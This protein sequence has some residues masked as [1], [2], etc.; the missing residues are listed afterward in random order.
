MVWR[1]IRVNDTFKPIYAQGAGNVEKGLGEVTNWSS[2]SLVRLQSPPPRPFH[3]IFVLSHSGN[4]DSCYGKHTKE[5]AWWMQL[6]L[7]I[8]GFHQPIAIF[9]ETM[10]T[11]T[12]GEGRKRALQA[13][14]NFNQRG[15]ALTLINKM[16]GKHTFIDERACQL[17]VTKTSS[18]TPFTTARTLTMR[19]SA[20]I[21]SCQFRRFLIN[22]EAYWSYHFFFSET[23]QPAWQHWRS[24]CFQGCLCLWQEL[25][26][27]WLQ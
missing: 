23:Y 14:A 12:G 15:R 26:C 6:I 20:L 18:F 21:F 10:Q 17:A 2:H 11:D 7:T 4:E 13:R 27:C 16:A 19:K 25:R 8:T 22:V 1:Y 24:K 5:P 3:E 9:E